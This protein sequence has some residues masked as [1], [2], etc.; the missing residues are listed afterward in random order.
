[1]RPTRPDDGL[2][3]RVI[4]IPGEDC[5]AP[6]VPASLPAMNR[7]E[8]P[9]MATIPV[10]HEEQRNRII[11]DSVRRQVRLTLA[12]RDRDGWRT[13][14]SRFLSASSAAGSL[15]AFVEPAS[16]GT[17][18]LLPTGDT[19]GVS[20]RIGHKKCMF[21]TT[22]CSH[23]PAE[24][25]TAFILAWPDHLQQLQRRVYERAVP[26]AGAVI[27]VR[28]RPADLASEAAA[29]HHV[30]HGQ[31]A[32]LSAGGMRIQVA[33]AAE[34]KLGGTCQC[35]FSPRIGA[36]TFVLEA[37]LLH[38]ELAEHGRAALGFH[39]IGL[40]TTAEGRRTLDRLARTVS[41]FQ[42]AHSRSGE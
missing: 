4:V 21:S 32:D 38:R 34:V 1:M 24:G 11:E 15:V 33:E 41:Q 12:H 23:E 20:F 8:G 18:L 22:L 3:L 31:L 40:E 13:Y 14:R 2:N 9:S 27:P 42:R 17:A 35:V 10:M 30:R 28:F 39:F 5:G 16:D 37:T 29:D 19:L 36:P 25:G 26:P 6:L 7:G